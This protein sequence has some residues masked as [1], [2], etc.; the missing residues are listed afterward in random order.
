MSFSVGNG[1]MRRASVITTPLIVVSVVF[2]VLAA[3]S[4]LLRLIAK[5]RGRQPFHA[6]DWWIIATWFLTF[7]MSVLFWVF[8][9]SSGIDFYDI[10]NVQGTYDSLE[11]AFLTACLLQLPLSS[12]KIS[13]LLFYKRIFQISR[14]FQV[15]IWVAIGL[16]TVWC[17]VFTV[18]VITHSD[19]ISESW[20]G[21]RMR[22]DM[23]AMGLAQV[24]S[25]IA[26]DVVV[27]C[28]PLP[29]VFSWLLSARK[30][31]MVFFMFWLGAFCCVAAIIR[32]VLLEQTLQ[33]FVESQQNISRQS[34]QYIFM[35]IEPNC[36]IIAACLPCYGP[37][38]ERIRGRTAES[39]PSSNLSMSYTRS[40]TSTKSAWGGST[41]DGS[42]SRRHDSQANLNTRYGWP[43]ESQHDVWY[44]DKGLA[45]KS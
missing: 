8:S 5:R 33:G 6:D 38:M 31:C 44:T 19:P 27:L 1:G 10:G 35:L 24:G 36:S 7:P 43:G 20:H 45:V 28:F 39:T 18:L 41:Y 32:L 2:P 40:R 9:A 15:C 42:F 12:V 21:G 17:L 22:Y 16:I 30:K 14:T 3:V 11:V 34:N 25:S 37:L 23:T 26:L 4:I 13:V 29:I